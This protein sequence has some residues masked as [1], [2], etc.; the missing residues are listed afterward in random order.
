MDV[1][2]NLNYGN[3]DDRHITDDE[4]WSAFSKCFLL[5]LNCNESYKFAFL[6]S[7][8]DNLYNTDK[9][10]V[11][12]FDQLFSTFA[13]LYW[14][15]ILNCKL[16]QMAA[17]NKDKRPALESLFIISAKM[18]GID[19]DTI[20]ES[21]PE[22]FKAN[23]NNQVKIKCKKNIVEELF[24]DT[25]KIFYSF[26]V[27]EEWI[28]F[29]PLMYEFVCKNKLIL[30]KVN[31]FEWAKFLEKAN[32]ASNAIHVLSKLNDC[33]KHNELSVHIDALYKDLKSDVCFYCGNKLNENNLHIDHFIP[34][35]YIKSDN[36]WN[37]VLACP[38]CK[39]QK[40]E[41]LPSSSYLS[42]LI[43]RNA[44]ILIKYRNN[45]ESMKNYRSNK[46]RFIYNMAIF[47]GYEGSWEPGVS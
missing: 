18:F 24:V 32:C 12:S 42:S 23:I 44:Q 11:L 14:N 37:L 26:N 9:Q 3:Y 7:I 21:L 30:E 16:R 28:K 45:D 40:S 27:S 39:G 43:G 15:L 13:E 46:L 17:S 41:S 36:L 6:K 5:Q 35:S 47:N 10:L 33:T 31:Y 1:G 4:K 22:K 34:W 2:Y 19:K 20:Y 25:N 8:L 38:E 29:N